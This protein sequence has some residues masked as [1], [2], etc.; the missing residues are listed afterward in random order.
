[1]PRWVH[2]LPKH[3]HACALRCARNPIGHN[4][5][6]HFAKLLHDLIT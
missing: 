5:F 1:M 4:N 2:A 6:L 3:F